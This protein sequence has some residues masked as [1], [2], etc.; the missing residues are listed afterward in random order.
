MEKWISLRQFGDGKLIVKIYP[1]V[2]ENDISRAFKLGRC[3]RKVYD[4][5]FHFYDQRYGEIMAAKKRKK[6]KTKPI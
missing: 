2:T 6:V 5:L 1:E 4:V 3:S